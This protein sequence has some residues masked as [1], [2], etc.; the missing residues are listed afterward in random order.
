MNGATVSLPR[1]TAFAVQH[2]ALVHRIEEG[3]Q[4]IEFFLSDRIILM[5]MAAAAVHGQPH[6]CEPHSFDSVNDG[7]SKPLFGNAPAFAIETSVAVES[8]GN[9]LILRRLGPQVPG[10][11]INCELVKGLIPIEGRNDPVA[12]GPHLSGR[13]HLKAVTVCIASEVQPLLG[14]A[15]AVVG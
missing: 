6:P 2:T 3:E 14:H 9:D 4:L 12:P 13:I 7:F 8:C 1:R 5:I 15:F 10:K 11:L